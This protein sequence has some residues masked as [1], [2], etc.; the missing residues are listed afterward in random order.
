MKIFEKHCGYCGFFF[1]SQCL[2]SALER[3][4]ILLSA[5]ARGHLN[6]NQLK[7]QLHPNVLPS[8]PVLDTKMQHFLP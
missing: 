2:Q 6:T 8:L 4:V 7:H 5:D 3:T 1:L